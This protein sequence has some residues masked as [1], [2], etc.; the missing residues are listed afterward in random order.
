MCHTVFDVK[1]NFPSNSPPRPANLPGITP[2][3]VILKVRTYKKAAPS[4][5]AFSHLSRAIYPINQTLI[6]KDLRD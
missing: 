6:L 1:K 4:R 3:I 5:A 2:K